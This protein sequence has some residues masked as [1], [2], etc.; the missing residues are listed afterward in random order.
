MSDCASDSPFVAIKAL[1]WSTKAKKV[2]GATAALWR[3]RSESSHQDRHTTKS[4]SKTDLPVF[5]RQRA[6][7]ICTQIPHTPYEGPSESPA[8][9]LESAAIVASVE[10][11]S[12]Y[13]PANTSRARTNTSDEAARHKPTISNPIAG[14]L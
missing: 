5:G 8:D 4:A 3:F 13:L 1:R 9:K 10:T 11:R 6:T 7:S 14:A 2:E 12:L